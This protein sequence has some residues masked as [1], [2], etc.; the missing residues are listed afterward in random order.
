M[1]FCYVLPYRNT[2]DRT[3]KVS[4]THIA[5]TKLKLSLNQK[6]Q[7]NYTWNGVGGRKKIGEKMLMAN[8]WNDIKLH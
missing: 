4:V 8:I 5:N 2:T 7:Q 6:L 1:C 3:G